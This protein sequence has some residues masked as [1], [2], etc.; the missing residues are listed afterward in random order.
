[1]SESNFNES[2]C[3]VQ[4]TGLTAYKRVGFPFPINKALLI[5]MIVTHSVNELHEFI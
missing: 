1:M 2:N 4:S 5:S 3:V